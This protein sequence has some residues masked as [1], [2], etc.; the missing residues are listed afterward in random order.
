MVGRYE[1]SAITGL[2]KRD[3]PFLKVDLLI[4]ANTAAITAMAAL[5]VCILACAIMLAVTG[6]P[7][8]MLAA[9]GSMGGG[10]TV[11]GVCQDRQAVG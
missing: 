7:A 2:V 1:W 4:C 3:N 6:D 10:L 9:T 8:W 5:A 11:Q